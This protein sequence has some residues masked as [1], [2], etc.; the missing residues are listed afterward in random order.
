M[1]NSLPYLTAQPH[2]T[3]SP[4]HVSE[5]M[6]APRHLNR[7]QPIMQ[8]K[9]AAATTKDTASVSPMTPNA[10]NC[11]IAGDSTLTTK[12]KCHDEVIT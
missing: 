7:A 11:I 6:I 4:A 9:N 10:E 2:T 3:T 12:E 8:P 5:H 1:S